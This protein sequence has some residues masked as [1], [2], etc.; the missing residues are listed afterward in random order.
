MMGCAGRLGAEVWGAA[1][2]V[3]VGGHSVLGGT[4]ELGGA[5]GESGVL[6]HSPGTATPPSHP[7]I[8][9]LAG[10][11]LVAP[12]AVALLGGEG[13]PHTVCVICRSGG[14]RG[15][16]GTSVAEALIPGRRLR[17]V[18]VTCFLL[19]PGEPGNNYNAGLFVHQ[20]VTNVCKS[21]PLLGHRGFFFSSLYFIFKSQP[22]Q[23]SPPRRCSTER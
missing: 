18:I 10:G 15:T 14:N 13:S 19:A 7:S 12:V 2:G 6:V 3:L 17:S 16:G 9:G 5:G 21:E 20:L 1:Q 8:W 23:I 4:A 11:L 22:V